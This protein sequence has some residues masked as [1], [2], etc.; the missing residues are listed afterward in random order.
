M[1]GLGGSSCS[2][3]AFLFC[4]CNYSCFLSCQLCVRRAWCTWQLLSVRLRVVP[5]LG[6][7]WTWPQQRWS[8][9]QLVMMAATAPQASTCLTEAAYHWHSVRVTTRGSSM[10]LVPPC[11]LM[12][13]I[14]GTICGGHNSCDI[15]FFKCLFSRGVN[16]SSS[17]YLDTS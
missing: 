5:V 10:W 9:L 7:V 8:V 13:A 4:S 2:L 14:T 11:L 16:Q 15:F 3:S 1:F 17:L 6:C 12:T